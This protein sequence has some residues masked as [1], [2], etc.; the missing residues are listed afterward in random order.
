MR[1]R[2]EVQTNVASFFLYL[3]NRVKIIIELM[4]GGGGNL[5]GMNF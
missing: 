1:Y 4:I 2:K 5:K 3:P